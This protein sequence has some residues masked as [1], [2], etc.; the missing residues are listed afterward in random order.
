MAEENKTNSDFD[1]RLA[2]MHEMERAQASIEQ[3]REAE[4]Q[5]NIAENQR[6]QEA[7]AARVGAKQETPAGKPAGDKPSASGPG[8]GSATNETAGAAVDAAKSQLKKQA[9]KSAWVALAPYLV[10]I[11]IIL[12]VIVIVGAIVLAITGYV[13]RN[14]S[15]GKT[16]F[17]PPTTLNEQAVLALA[18][19]PD[20]RNLAI[21]T[22]AET[23]IASLKTVEE[24]AVRE[25]NDLCLQKV[26]ELET[27]LLSLTTNDPTNTVGSDVIEKQL[28]DM[29]KN[30][31]NPCNKYSSSLKDP[32][33]ALSQLEDI[34]LT[35]L[36][37]K[38]IISGKDKY[39]IRTH[40]VDNRILEALKYL[41][42]PTELGGAGFR[43]IKVRRIKSE[44]DST[45]RQF[46]REWDFTSDED[47]SISPHFSGQAMDIAG[48]DMVDRRLYQKGILR[49]KITAKPPVD[50]MVI[51]QSEA[52]GKGSGFSSPT[53]GVG[54]SFGELFQNQG[55]ADLFSL[56]GASTGYDFS[57]LNI[58]EGDSLPQIVKAMGLLALQE[59]IGGI[60]INS[61]ED[62]STADKLYGNIGKNILSD[63]LKI[64]AKGLRGNT[65]DEIQTNIGREIVAER[66]GLAE[67]SLSGTTSDEILTSLG[68]RKIESEFGIRLG[69]LDYFVPNGDPASFS[70]F[71]GQV[72]IEQNLNLA[73]G[74]FAPESLN[75]IKENV[76]IDKWNQLFQN[77]EQVDAILNLPPEQGYSSR[78]INGLSPSIYKKAVGDS[79][80]NSKA[81]GFV[82]HAAIENYSINQEAG[83]NQGAL[84]Y[85]G[86][87]IYN[88]QDEV[89][90]LPEGSMA[91]ILQNDL[92]VFHAIGIDELAKVLAK[93]DNMRAVIVK[94]LTDF[95]GLPLEN[96]GYLYSSVLDTLYIRYPSASGATLIQD[97]NRAETI[98]QD[99][100]TL[101]GLKQ[102]SQ[103]IAGYLRLLDVSESQKQAWEEEK[104]SI[105]EKIR[106][107]SGDQSIW[108]YLDENQLN[109]EHGLL[110][111]AI[112]N[113]F[114]LNNGEDVF[115]TI[116]ANKV[117]DAEDEQNAANTAIAD[118]SSIAKLNFL[119][120]Q[121]TDTQN[122]LNELKAKRDSGDTSAETAGQIRLYEGNLNLWDNEIRMENANL[123]SRQNLVN[124]NSGKNIGLNN[125]DVTSMIF[126]S[127]EIGRELGASSVESSLGLPSGSITQTIKAGKA[128]IDSRSIGSAY[129]EETLS[130]PKESFKGTDTAE[131]I[132]SVGGNE[133][134]FG[135]FFPGYN[136]QDMINNLP[137]RT[138]NEAWFKNIFK[139]ADTLFG[140]S[141]NTTY[142]LMAGDITPDQYAGKVGDSHLKDYARNDITKNLNLEFGGYILNS[143]DI[144]DLLNGNYLGV[145]LKI[146]AKNIDDG[147]SLPV[148]TIKAMIENPG[149]NC[150]VQVA[151]DGR[152]QSCIENLLAVNGEEQLAHF[153]G[154]YGQASVS[155]NMSESIGQEA[156]ENALNQLHPNPALPNG[157]FTGDSTVGIATNIAKM[158]S[159][160]LANF[161]QYNNEGE[162][163]LIQKFG[164]DLTQYGSLNQIK[165]TDFIENSVPYNLGRT[166]DQKLGVDI[167][168]T[169]QFLRQEISTKDYKER[170]QKAYATE[171]SGEILYGQLP[172]EVQKKLTKYGLT[173]QD[174]ADVIS[175]PESI[176]SKALFTALPAQDIA[177][178]TG[179][180]INL[181][182]KGDFPA[183]FSQKLVEETLGLAEGS[184]SPNSSISDV[185]RINGAKKFSASFR[186]NLDYSQ[187]DAVIASYVSA[188]VS[189][190]GA[191]YWGDPNN[192]IRAQNI[193]G[194]LKISNITEED[195]KFNEGPTKLLLQNRISIADYLALIQ[196]YQ[197]A[198]T[199]TQDFLNNFASYLITGDPTSSET[200][201]MKNYIATGGLVYGIFKDPGFLRTSEGQITVLSALKKVGHIDVDDKLGFTA[202]TMENLILHPDKSKSILMAQGMRAM[203]EKVF[204]GDLE[205]QKNNLI[206][207]FQYYIPGMDPNYVINPGDANNS[208]GGARQAMNEAE[209]K[210]I[211]QE[212]RTICSDLIINN[213]LKSIIHDATVIKDKNGQSIAGGD[214][215][216]LSDEDLGLLYKGDPKVM[217]AMGMAFTVNKL[218]AEKDEN[219]N[220]FQLLPPEFQLSYADIKNVMWASEGDK[221]KAAGIASANYTQQY[222]EKNKNLPP[223]QLTNGTA[224]PAY[225]NFVDGQRQAIASAQSQIVPNARKELQYRY[226]DAQIAATA[227]MNGLPPIPFGFSKTM[228]SGTEDE[229]N[230]MLLAYGVNYILINNLLPDDIKTAA[231]ALGITQALSQFAVDRNMDHLKNAFSNDNLRNNFFGFLDSELSKKV[232]IALPQDTAKNIYYFATGD[233]NKITSGF[234]KD[235]LEGQ[236]GSLLDKQ[237]GL[238]SGTSYTLYH[239][240]K[241]MQSG[242]IGQGD[243]ILIAVNLVFGKQLMKLD[244]QMGLPPGSTSSILGAVTAYN[245]SGLGFNFYVAAAI[246]LYT[247][248]FGFSKSEIQITCVGD[249]TFTSWCKE[250]DSL[251]IQWSQANTRKL[252]TDMLKIGDRM[253]DNDLIPTIMGTFRQEDVD[254]LEGK[255]GASDD[256]ITKYYGGASM[257][258]GV[259]GLY[260]SDYMKDFVHV[261]Y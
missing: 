64:P 171:K 179:F 234:G 161:A 23:M 2:W 70:I 168:T 18:N 154:I 120:K 238:P 248:L 9:L 56:L 176:F 19:E 11:F 246:A 89:W 143:Q 114:R 200:Q 116:G 126:K 230:N 51:R 102:R 91:R 133:K 229:R 158:I 59:E 198:R 31:N 155:S 253:S 257:I 183:N 113:I 205:G 237:L 153:M 112:S 15:A 177:L 100:A 67:G 32:R 140:L 174:I 43:K 138:E 203:S 8:G 170:A 33:A 92:S 178:I 90:N 96:I 1:D 87:P 241:L 202:G 45:G 66:L 79:L 34:L 105:E 232:G 76:G 37:S 12:A 131:L 14:G 60:I 82:N 68:K 239:N 35:T 109:G 220:N 74:S 84:L 97:I 55:L 187:T 182:I 223:P 40:Q 118:Q 259:K 240:Y 192:I 208:C 195:T 188:N 134:I 121:L 4:R 217:E 62:N 181:P 58:K 81:S 52:V 260:Q 261:G 80:L 258:R 101:D 125:F 164:F 122:K 166:L 29:E 106:I 215:I 13:L 3:H 104:A 194:I 107:G 132:Q 218:K 250:D 227:R 75:Q 163:R 130:M 214:G 49:T 206:T 30:E 47:R 213:T 136:I 152:T 42:R 86:A 184:F 5:R 28:A 147:L 224:N 54:S 111:D 119:N 243:L 172:E 69:S 255:D 222:V 151:N 211:V 38:V 201:K 173:S 146:G 219:G 117:S 149:T 190:Q 103:A 145:A 169:A 93:N 46:S 245:I 235:F 159:P 95:K 53:S 39:Y 204:F 21:N 44:Y 231:N 236:I 61:Q 85:A 17:H 249:Y 20:A 26:R 196:K 94:W 207:L 148:G 137:I 167:G 156:I 175:N 242:K 6:R 233:T 209:A 141:E 72:L 128:K 162:K 160:V 27:N 157:W 83:P 98:A 63:Y 210:K 124:K 88:E 144:T 186:L 251:Y 142:A 139:S 226:A 225:I 129:I 193:D 165:N 221:L 22:A 135:Y 252:I 110:L 197:F 254:F 180:G 127:D 115:Y 41:V 36:S 77:P 57:Q 247:I 123:Q 16:A 189:K 50:I 191:S 199:D 7:E 256:L 150:Q 78:L 73:G 24:R 216:F 244:S 10:P 108:V 25:Q 228:M 99:Q 71:V 212:H 48:I 185:I 65:E